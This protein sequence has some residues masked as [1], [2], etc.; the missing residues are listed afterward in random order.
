M[1]V[2]LV[3]QLWPIAAAG[4]GGVMIG[5]V[6]ARR[7]I[8]RQLN[9]ICQTKDVLRSAQCVAASQL[10]VLEDL[11]SRLLKGR[12]WES[13][14]DLGEPKHKGWYYCRVMFSVGK[15]AFLWVH[16]IEGYRALIQSKVTPTH[17]CGPFIIPPFD[18]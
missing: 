3:S 10:A 1:D 7:K 15:P 14:E 9:D 4:I 17:Y 6:L 5:G 16:G 2:T 12:K 11:N 13:A 8:T 18:R